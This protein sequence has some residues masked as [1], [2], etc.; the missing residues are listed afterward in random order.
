MREELGQQT[1]EQLLD[2]SWQPERVGVAE[3][4]LRERGQRHQSGA[5]ERATGRGARGR[6]R[7]EANGWAIFAM[8]CFILSPH[9]GT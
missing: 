5:E 7:V 4:R 8:A 9:W 3:K 2:Y 1:A 6:A